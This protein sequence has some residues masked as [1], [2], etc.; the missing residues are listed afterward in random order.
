MVSVSVSCYLFAVQQVS[1][2]GVEHNDLVAKKVEQ[3]IA[4]LMHE[5][6]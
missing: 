3:Y 1:N 2:L 5:V 4:E 6:T